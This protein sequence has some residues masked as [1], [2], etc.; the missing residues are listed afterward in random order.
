M[1]NLE[2]QPVQALPWSRE[3]EQ[4]LPGAFQMPTRMTALSFA[5]D[6]LALVSAVPL[7]PADLETIVRMGTVK[8]LIAPNLLHHLYLADAASHFPDAKVLA[9]RKLRTKRPD[10][11]IDA[12]LE[13]GLPNDMRSD[14]ELVR[15]EGAPSVDEFVF[16]HRPSG[17]AVVTDL[18]FNMTNP[19]G[20]V[21]NFTLWLVGCHKRFA[22]SRAWRFFIKDRKAA[23]SSARRL[24]DLPVLSVLPAHGEAVTHD[25]RTRLTTALA[26]M[27]DAK[28]E[29]R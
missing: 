21:A 4:T 27:A 2:T 13:D 9:P 7:T 26:W 28:Q 14:V 23:A 17:C 16:F 15:I 12:D 18:L 19:K 22:Q 3:H 24:L 8:Y 25:A 5:G 29:D 20:A 11:R 6:H 1:V 10:L